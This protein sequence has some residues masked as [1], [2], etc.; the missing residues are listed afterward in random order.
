MALPNLSGS[1]IQDTYQRVLHTDGSKIYDGVG[2]VVLESTELSTLQTLNNNTV[3]NAD[4]A[5]VATMDQHVNE[6]ASISAADFKATG[7][8]TAKN[9]VA[10][11]I[12]CSAQL[13]EN[14]FGTDVTVYGRI[15]TIGSEVSINTGSIYATNT[16]EASDILTTNLIATGKVRI[17]GSDI[18]LESGSISAS[19]DI[20][21]THSIIAGGNV[22]AGPLGTGSFDHI[23]TTTGS[24][25]FRDGGTTIGFMRMSNDGNG[26]RHLNSNRVLQNRVADKIAGNRRIGGVTFDG[27]SSISLPGV[28]EAGT[29]DT[30]GTAAT[31]SKVPYTGLT[32][33]VP[34]WNQATTGNAGSVTNGVYDTGN[35]T[36]A[37][38]KTFSSAINGDL[39]GN[40]L[41]ATQ[42][43]TTTTYK[44]S[45]KYLLTPSDFLMHRTPNNFGVAGSFI[46]F[47]AGEKAYCTWT[48]P[49]G[50]AI[51][52]QR[53]EVI[54]TKGSFTMSMNLLDGSGPPTPIV[55]ALVGSAVPIGGLSKNFNAEK[56]FLAIEF[57]TAPGAA[58]RLYSAYVDWIIL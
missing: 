39:K 10:D 17:K 15:R 37:G 22:S 20:F 8:V 50:S 5:Y 43:T 38:T 48:M 42:A 3:E 16:I 57:N 54:A 6:T 55:S 11:T 24:I 56:H 21:C 25:E 40:A 19:G 46:G 34:T 44:N 28:D 58:A 35:Q 14:I 13:G 18:A 31:A 49:L 23:I 2:N 26:L 33:A 53:V 12:S 4:W 47:A 7:K 51:W 9:V 32:G 1:I 30:S 36:I 29:Q 52:K 45:N 41:S 27:L